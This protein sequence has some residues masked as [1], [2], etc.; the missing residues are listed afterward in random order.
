MYVAHI[1]SYVNIKYV[2]SRHVHYTYAMHIAALI[3]V[4]SGYSNF[5]SL[6]TEES[7][8]YFLTAETVNYVL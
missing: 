6:I 2:C 3:K 7:Y 5:S 1:F 4:S 8:A